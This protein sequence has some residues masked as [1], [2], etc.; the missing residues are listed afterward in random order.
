VAGICSG[1]FG[2]GG[3]IVL[4]PLLV[5]ILGLSQHA[6]NGTSLVALLLPVG[7]LGVLAY[8]QAGKISVEHI[9]SG[10][11]IALGIFLGT[12]LGA[13]FSVSL[14]EGVL[15]KAFAVFLIVIGVQLWVSK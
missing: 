12:Y 14:S 15:R 3:G 6:A 10:L 9:K 8:Y 13:R 1:V 5:F 2:I 11:V 7:A 4:I